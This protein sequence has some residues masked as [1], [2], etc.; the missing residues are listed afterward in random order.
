[1]ERWD[2]SPHSDGS[3]S[4][5]GV[6]RE[7]SGPCSETFWQ[8]CR[9]AST[10]VGN[11]P[12][13]IIFHVEVC[14]WTVWVSVN[15]PGWWRGCSAEPQRRTCPWISRASTSGLRYSASSGRGGAGLWPARGW[16]DKD[17]SHMRSVGPRNKHN[18][19]NISEAWRCRC[20]AY[21]S[22]WP[23]GAAAA[24]LTSVWNRYY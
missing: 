12:P 15:V 9:V 19:V 3:H 14:S 5:A 7:E 13:G 21:V 6:G 8:S 1:M 17:R 18:N 4:T 11:I 16:P 23:S 10:S 2:W 20:S 24:S 22:R